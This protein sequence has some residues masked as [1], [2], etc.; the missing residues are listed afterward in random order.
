AWRARYGSRPSAG[1]SRRD[2]RGRGAW[3][4]HSWHTPG[5]WVPPL[6]SAEQG[7]RKAPRMAQLRHGQMPILRSPPRIPAFAR[8]GAGAQGPSTQALKE[9]VPAFAGTNGEAAL[10][11]RLA[12]RIDDL[13]ELAEHM[14]AGQDLLQ[15][16]GRLAL[17]FDGRDEL[18]VLKLDAVHRDVDLGDVDLVVLAVGEVVVERLIG[19]VVAD[20]A[21]E[22][23]KRTVVVERQRQGQD[24]PR[25]H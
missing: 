19:A 22:R 25:R 14:H 11:V 6:R 21:E 13:L 23:A 3:F 10:R 8:T 16:R 18:A 20:V 12:L 5:I 15:A 24:R 4:W 17:A 2:R 1:S 7:G 9:W